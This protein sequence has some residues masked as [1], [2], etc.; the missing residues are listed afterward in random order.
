MNTALHPRPRAARKSNDETIE[1]LL[2][3]ELW[4][5]RGFA[6]DFEHDAG[7]RAPL[8]DKLWGY[9][10]TR[11]AHTSKEALEGYLLAC[12]QRRCCRPF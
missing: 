4:E 10:E 6:R 8:V 7:T 12:A 2:A 11:R 1:R 9:P 3:R 5:N